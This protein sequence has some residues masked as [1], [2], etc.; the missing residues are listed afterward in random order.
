[1]YT[2]MRLLK[3]SMLAILIYLS[4]HISGQVVIT[5]SGE[6]TTSSYSL[7]DLQSHNKGV[8]LPRLTE[9][10]MINLGKKLTV[11]ETGMM[12][13]C[14]DSEPSGI[15]SFNFE[16][17]NWC[18]FLFSNIIQT[19]ISTST[20]FDNRVPSI[21]ATKNYINE[22]ILL[23]RLLQDNSLQLADL[24]KNGHDAGGV[25]IIN[26]GYPIENNDAATKKYVDL[27]ME[28][29]NYLNMSDYL[30]KNSIDKIFSE[31]IKLSN[32]VSIIST[33]NSELESNKI[34]VP[35]IGA[36]KG[37]SNNK[38]V[39]G[40]NENQNYFQEGKTAT[41]LLDNSKILV[42]GDNNT[43]DI[44]YLTKN[45]SAFTTPIYISHKQ[46]TSTYTSAFNNNLNPRFDVLS[47]TENTLMLTTD[48]FHIN[49]DF[50]ILYQR[51]ITIGGKSIF[52][53]S[54]NSKELM[55]ADNSIFKNIL[56]TDSIHING[57][58]TLKKTVYLKDKLTVHGDVTIESPSTVQDSLIV[59]GLTDFQDEVN[60]LE[61]GT[62]NAMNNTIL[63][64]NTTFQTFSKLDTLKATNTTLNSLS[65]SKG[66]LIKGNIETK[67]LIVNGHAKVK[68]I[69]IKSNLN[70][71]SSVRLNSG[72]EVELNI[73]VTENAT[74]DTLEVTDTLKVQGET[75]FQQGI[76][77]DKNYNN[78]L[79]K[80]T[81]SNNASVEKM[82]IN[83]ISTITNKVEFNGDITIPSTGNINMVSAN[84]SCI[85]NNSLIVN[86]SNS[87]LESSSGS[88]ITV[89]GLTE[90]LSADISYSSNLDLTT[91]RIK[92]S[93]VTS[94]INKLSSTKTTI[95]TAP[96]IALNTSITDNA[97]RS[98]N[99]M[100][101][102]NMKVNSKSTITG[103][104]AADRLEM[105]HRL[106]V[107][108][109]TNS[110][111]SVSKFMFKT[112]SFAGDRTFQ[113]KPFHVINTL[114]QKFTSGTS[115]QSFTLSST[116]SIIGELTSGQF[117]INS[118]STE[119]DIQVNDDIYVGGTIYANT[120]NLF[121]FVN[122]TS[123]LWD[124]E[125]L[126]SKLIH[127]NDTVSIRVSGDTEFRDRSIT[128]RLIIIGNG[129]YII[130]KHALFVGKQTL[131][132]D[133]SETGDVWEKLLSGDLDANTSHTSDYK[134]LYSIIVDGNMRVTKFLLAGNT[135]MS[136][137]V[138]IKKVI[139]HRRS[140][141]SLELINKIDIVDY[142]KKDKIKYGN[143]VEKK[144]IAQQVE[145]HFPQ[146]VSKVTRFIPNVYKTAESYIVKDNQTTIFID[147]KIDVDNIV[148]LI[149]EEYSVHGDKIGEMRVDQKVTE[150][151]SKSFTVKQKNKYVR[152]QPNS[153]VYIFVF[154]TEV[155]DFRVVD[156]DGISMLNLSATQEIYKL[157]K[158]QQIKQI[159]QNERIKE[160]KKT[161]ERLR[162]K[163]TNIKNRFSRLQ[164]VYLK[165]H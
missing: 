113:N 14:T 146:V 122:T 102:T 47:D 11:Y 51:S 63:N 134:A 50:E 100:S 84:D 8:L 29:A 162:I 2:N 74:S 13:Y 97:N 24:L 91:F 131:T 46:N 40:E 59:D 39:F 53:Q 7:L 92:N 20:E 112:C 70:S 31:H 85:V 57:T 101:F 116:G 129:S 87:D 19:N 37:L 106:N 56:T 68:D 110:T 75:T 41:S 99:S 123:T 9:D 67:D 120:I 103:T 137:D 160:N 77:I 72:A 49:G 21:G 43:N 159:E 128:N 147:N 148:R 83:S 163:N 15:Y 82:T 73:I 6:Y 10:S 69:I 36:I 158:E 90:I 104:I 149:Y 152:R 141:K 139:G 117:K 165:K 109:V 157:L 164:E 143:K 23:H 34:K 1:M 62:L 118:I 52:K 125:S 55:V 66:T 5:S 58:T 94:N 12:V 28:T 89:K 33:E 26:V 121:N 71:E 27:K 107:G 44:S 130:G 88:I 81:I 54:I 30:N 161:M 126:Y 133:R 60:I 156:Y 114:G 38:I 78:I 124:L 115:G 127:C 150:V 42:L 119:D 25:K 111:G 35:T 76:Q 48:L 142:T 18:N 79:N 105:H 4:N 108:N 96:C 45:Q 136:S 22:K 80:F 3:L 32:I 151:N 140:E 144:V 17:K 86:G 93:L 145:Q 153:E 61:T 64:G 138:R 98:V 16:E 154:G 95:F 65:I 132:S 155:D 135:Y